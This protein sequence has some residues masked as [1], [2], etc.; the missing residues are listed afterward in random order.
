MQSVYQKALHSSK[1]R[2]D[3]FRSSAVAYMTINMTL[4]TIINEKN[5]LTLPPGTVMQTS[6]VEEWVDEQTKGG[7]ADTSL[8]ASVEIVGA[9]K[10]S[11]LVF[12]YSCLFD[13]IY[14]I[15]FSVIL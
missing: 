5:A 12:L 11:V 4:S 10:I 1:D 9:G 13:V 15:I 7:T 3:L 8:L 6:K 2:S 14:D